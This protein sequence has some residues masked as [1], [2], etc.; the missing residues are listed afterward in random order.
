MSPLVSAIVI[1]AIEAVLF[2]TL[3]KPMER[4]M[5][6]KDARRAGSGEAAIAVGG[7][8]FCA[9]GEC[10]EVSR[11]V[12]DPIARRVTHVVVSDLGTEVP[13]WV[14]PVAA[15]GAFAGGVRLEC[16]KSELHAMDPVDRAEVAA[17]NATGRASTVIYREEST[18]TAM[19]RPLDQVRSPDG[20]VGDA[21]GILTAAEDPVQMTH[22]LVKA[23]PG[24]KL[25]AVPGA[26][27]SSMATGFQ[28]NLPA[29]EVG[30]LPAYVGGAAT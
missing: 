12:L 23:G 24:R 14:V 30:K 25:V 8:A 29:A 17:V 2:M 22:L 26:W 9:D 16:T 4:S 10:G 5:A 21:C 27:I 13:G 15:V 3:K 28:L 1:L 18:A 6:D 7:R 11:I 20:I 19:V